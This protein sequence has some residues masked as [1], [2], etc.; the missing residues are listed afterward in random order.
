[1]AITTA[2]KPSKALELI[3]YQLIITSANMQYPLYVW[4]RVHN[5][6]REGEYPTLYYPVKRHCVIMLCNI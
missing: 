4:P 1:M 2:H 5:I 3:A 6:Y